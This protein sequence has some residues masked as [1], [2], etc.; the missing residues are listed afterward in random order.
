MLLLC[1][2]LGSDVCVYLTIAVVDQVMLLLLFLLLI[3]S[4]EKASSPLR[5]LNGEGIDR[6][7]E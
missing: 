4:S 5:V 2:P 7:S 6:M 3:S 1:N